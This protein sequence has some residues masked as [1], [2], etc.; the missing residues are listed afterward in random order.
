MNL[1][2]VTPIKNRHIGLGT[3]SCELNL[4]KYLETA[5]QMHR[6]KQCSDWNG[7][8]CSCPHSSHPSPGL[9][10]PWTASRVCMPQAY[11]LPW[12]WGTAVLCLCLYETGGEGAWSVLKVG[13][14]AQSCCFNSLLFTLG[15]W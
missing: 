4:G 15:R 14:C 9:Q 7:S 5:G 12:W 11:A 8:K 1:L 13:L 6:R 10:L 2:I 3:L